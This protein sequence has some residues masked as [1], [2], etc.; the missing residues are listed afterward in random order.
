MRSQRKDEHVALALQEE[1]RENDFDLIRFYHHSFPGLSMEDVSLETMYMDRV[2]SYP[3]YIN[4]MTG[5]SEKTAK[6]NASLAKIAKHYDLMMVLGSQHAALDNPE[7]E[8]SY[9]IVR[10][11]NPDGFIVGNVNPNA[12]VED[13]KRA[14]EMVDADALSIHVNSAQE[15]TMEEG[16]RD[17]RY[18]LDNIAAIIRSVE[19]PV[20]VKEVGFGMSAYTVHQLIQRGVEY[21]DVSGRGGT[22]FIRIENRRLEKDRFSYLESWGLSTA[23]SLLDVGTLSPKISVFASGGIRNPLDVVKAFALGADAVGLSSYFLRIS[24]LESFEEQTA[25]LDA[26]FEDIARIMLLLG[27]DRVSSL[28]ETELILDGKLKRYV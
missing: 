20:I 4:A 26:F 3:V 5:G 25:V 23:E 7:L 13:A 21:V 1:I 11:V 8:A 2:F 10:E 12:S 9:R 19:V 17:F 18:W 15:L 14:I 28:S 22:N 6:I 24:Q 16:D 27:K